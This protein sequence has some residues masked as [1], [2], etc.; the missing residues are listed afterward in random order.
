MHVT[1]VQVRVKP[2]NTNDFIEATRLNH[3]Q[4]RQEPGNVRFDVLQ[5]ADDPNAFVLYEAYQSANDAAAHK[6]TR[7]YLT[8]RET[9]APWMAQPRQGITYHGLFPSVSK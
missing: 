6:E 9:V 4:S 5:C 1:I 2:E 8:W 3:E 7:H